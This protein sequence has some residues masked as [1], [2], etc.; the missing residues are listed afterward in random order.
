M[1]KK[2]KKNKKGA[3]NPAI[4]S[5]LIGLAVLIII[6]FLVISNIRIGSK[7]AE[8]IEKINKFRKEIQIMETKNEQLKAGIIE[9]ESEIFWEEKAREQGYKKPDE[10]QVVILPPE[11]RKEEP[12]GEEKGFWQKVW[13]KLGL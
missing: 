1:I 2:F 10:E 4:I 8:L 12:L 7:R 5:T 3:R 6:G 11:E 9:T 13:E